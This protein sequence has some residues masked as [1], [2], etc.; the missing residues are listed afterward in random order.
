MG[1]LLDKALSAYSQSDIDRQL[2]ARFFLVLCMVILVV[3]VVLTILAAFIQHLNVGYVVNS[4]I[5]ALFLGMA[6]VCFVMFMLVR[7]RFFLASHLLILAIMATNWIVMIVDPGGPVARLDSFV[8]IISLLGLLPL[9]IH[10]R[11]SVIFLYGLVNIVF[12]FVFIYFFRSQMALQDYAVMDF[13]TDNSLAVITACFVAASVF[14]INET[15]LRK[16][17]AEIEERKR[18]EEKR[19]KLEARLHQAEKMEAIGQLAGKMAHDFN[20]MLSVV[21]GNT[22]LIKMQQDIDENGMEQLATIQY[23]ASRSSDLIKQLLAFARKQTVVPKIVDINQAISNMLPMLY[24]LAGG[25]IALKWMPGENTGRIMIDPSQMDQ[26]LANLLVNARDAIGTAGIITIETRAVVLDE[27]CDTGPEETQASGPYVMLAVSDNGCGMNKEVLDQAFEPFFSTKKGRG[28]G[29]GLATVDGIVRQN[30]GVVRVYSEPGQGTTFKI[31][32]PAV[33][34]EAVAEGPKPATGSLLPR[35]SETILMVEDNP[36]ILKF[37][38]TVL[39]QL[40]YTVLA[41]DMPGK[42][43]E[44]ARSGRYRID[45]LLTDVIMPDMNGHELAQQV[46]AVI[47]GIRCLYISG[48]TANAISNGDLIGRDISFLAKPF[49][50]RELAEKVREALS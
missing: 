24:Q 19:I 12:L 8:Y 7:G 34:G 30:S 26:I 23:V 36:A 29:L 50:I 21:I 46:Q 31:Y 17:K 18:A 1:K 40:G 32:F 22:E 3:M 33:E 35:G 2:K 25:D 28:T 27:S 37:G 13:L 16:A 11:K 15:A 20:N 49:S 10:H 38:A 47:P 5:V 45:L 42:A 41:V 43:L 6:C 4:V 9:V 44:L 14:T 39:E 48:Y